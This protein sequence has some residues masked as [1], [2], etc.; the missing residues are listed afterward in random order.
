MAFMISFMIIIHTVFRGRQWNEWLYNLNRLLFLSCH[1]LATEDQQ[2]LKRDFFFQVPVTGAQPKRVWWNDSYLEKKLNRR[3]PRRD[4]LTDIESVLGFIYKR[5]S[6][7]LACRE[8][9][10]PE[11]TL[12]TCGF[13]LFSTNQD[14]R[15]NSP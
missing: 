11:L 4:S 8:K 13:I 15:V 7:P 10:K 3:S 1:F 14:C 12:F 6:N 2:L 5:W 9:Y